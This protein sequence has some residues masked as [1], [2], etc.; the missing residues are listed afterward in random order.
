MVQKQYYVYILASKPYGI[1]YIGVTSDLLRRVQEHQSSKIEGFSKRYF[2]KRLVYF[3]ETDD[4]YVAITK[5]KQLK[6]WKRAWKIRLIEEVN[7][8]WDDLFPGLVH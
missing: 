4:V 7:P 5:E 1:L 6:V 3:E 8:P 2:V